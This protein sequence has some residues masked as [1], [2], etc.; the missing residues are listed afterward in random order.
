MDKVKDREQ[1]AIFLAL[2]GRIDPI[3]TN[4]IELYALWNEMEEK[5]RDAYLKR[6]KR[7]LDT[8]ER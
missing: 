6:A 8:W 3:P 4:R 7:L 1:L 5:H 2:G